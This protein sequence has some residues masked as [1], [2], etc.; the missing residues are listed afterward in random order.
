MMNTIKSIWNDSTITRTTYNLFTLLCLLLIAVASFS[1][2]FVNEA[3]WLIWL[4]VGVAVA[5]LS[6]MAMWKRSRDITENT[7]MGVVIFAIV[8]ILNSY[9]GVIGYLILMC[10]PSHSKTLVGSS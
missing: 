8:I 2:L 1:L 9:S 10:V 6:I 4:P 7:G 5:L 3:I